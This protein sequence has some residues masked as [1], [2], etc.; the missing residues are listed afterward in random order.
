M[1]V[2]GDWQVTVKSTMGVQEGTLTLLAEGTALSGK[3]IIPQG[4]QTFSKGKANGN[5]L[6]WNI[7]LTQPMPM[8]VQFTALVSGDAISGKVKLGM[9]GNATFAGT[10][11]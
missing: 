8:D 9:F 5:N 6:S 1:S 4:T 7:K 10:R 2:S 11:V 3:V